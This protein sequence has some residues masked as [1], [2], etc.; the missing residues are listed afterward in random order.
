GSKVSDVEHPDMMIFDLDPSEGVPWPRVLR[1][2]AG[3]RERLD[4]LG[5][6]SFPR[7]TG[8]KGLHLVVPLEPH[9]DWDAVKAFA[10]AVSE[11]QASDDPQH[12]T[13]NLSKTK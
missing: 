8:G 12:L 3:L 13:T 10:K 9:A 5:L 7:T 2:A 1:A 6:A 11:R 4:A